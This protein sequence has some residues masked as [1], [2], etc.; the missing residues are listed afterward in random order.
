MRVAGLI[1]SNGD[2]TSLFFVCYELQ[3]SITLAISIQRLIWDLISSDGWQVLFIVM[4]MEVME[5]AFF[6]LFFLL[7]ASIT[8]AISI[9]RLIWDLIWSDQMAFSGA[10]LYMFHNLCE[11]IWVILF[12][13][14]W[15][16]YEWKSVEKCV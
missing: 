7:R 10:Q 14:F 11:E 13:F 4:A 8:L 16:M 1:Y 2:G 15:N 12:V 9:Q 5:L 6:F 3:S